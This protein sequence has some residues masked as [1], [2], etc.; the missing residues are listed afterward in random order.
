VL[1]ED[2]TDGCPMAGRP[3]DSKQG[4]GLNGRQDVSKGSFCRQRV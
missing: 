4:L 2:I 3:D 1:C